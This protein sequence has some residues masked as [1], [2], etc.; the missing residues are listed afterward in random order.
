MSAQG[1]EVRELP[2]ENNAPTVRETCAQG[3]EVRELPPRCECLELPFIVDELA[4]DGSDMDSPWY[5]DAF[6]AADALRR[7]YRNCT[8][9]GYQ[10]APRVRVRR[11]VR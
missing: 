10:P 4:D 3:I 7:Y 8:D 5:V 11:G 2:P 6:S 1:I 9:H